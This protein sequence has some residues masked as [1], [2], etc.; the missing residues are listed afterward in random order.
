MLSQALLRLVFIEQANTSHLIG[1]PLAYASL[2][3]ANVISLGPPSKTLK[4]KSAF[5]LLR[6]HP[7]IRLSQSWSGH[8]WSPGYYM[9][10][11]GNM[12]KEVVEKYIND[13][14]YNEMK[15]A[16]YKV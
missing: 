11:S 16:L 3:S 7:E 15:K 13:Q 4:D 6:R 14:K 5:I 9:S 8:L 2:A 12:S 1:K 10:T